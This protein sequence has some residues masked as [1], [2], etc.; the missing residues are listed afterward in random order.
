MGKSGWL[1]SIF[2]ALALGGCSS[3][4]DT[5]SNDL[6]QALQQRLSAN[7]HAVKSVFGVGESVYVRSLAVEQE[8]QHL[9]VG[10]SAGVHEIDLKDQNPLNTFTRD[11]GLANEYVFAIHVDPDGYKWFGTNAG[12]MTRYKDGDWKTFFPMHGLA[13]YW[14]YSFADAVDGSLWVGT[15]AGVNHMNRQTEQ[16]DTYVAELVNEWVYGIGRDSKGNIWFGTEGGVT[17]FDGN[18]WTSWTHKDGMGA[19]NAQQLPF[20]TNTGLGTRNRHDLGILAGGEATYNPNY[21][22]SVL[23]DE[24]DRVFVGTWGAGVSIYEAGKWRN[25]TTQDGLAGNVV[26]SIARDQIGNYWFGTN[27]GVSRFD[28]E[29]WQTIGRAN[30]LPSQDVY[31][32]AIDAQGDVWAGVRGSVVQITKK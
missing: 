11:D 23:V 24:Q 5:Q 12:G 16:M 30:G 19:E 27:G 25:L 32:L 10:T 9:W 14:I 2:L 4:K 18:E 20:S 1:S 22:F 7:S 29:T 28:G 6:E 21:V 8:N 13:D 3:E 15:W 17:R 31:A 26:Y